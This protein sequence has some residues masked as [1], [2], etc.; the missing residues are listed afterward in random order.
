MIPMKDGLY[1]I[2][3]INAE[4]NIIH[5]LDSMPEGQYRVISNLVFNK[6]D[7]TNSLKVEK[8]DDKNI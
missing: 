7:N 4:T 3:Y 8:K 1:N 6:R 5:T 2:K